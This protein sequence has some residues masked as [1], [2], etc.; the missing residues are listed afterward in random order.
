MI[1]L[2]TLHL[3]TAQKVFDQVAKH[4]LTQNE[5]CRLNNKACQCHYNH[6]RCAAI[7]TMEYNP[8]F[9]GMR[10]VECKMN[11]YM[12][13]Q[14]VMRYPSGSAICGFNCRID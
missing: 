4:L 8:R 1:T 9:E 6:L 5:A 2:A 3:A 7:S 13:G 11:K 10:E 12:T 14:E